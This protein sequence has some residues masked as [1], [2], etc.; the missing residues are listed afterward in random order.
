MSYET[1]IGTVIARAKRSN[2]CC[3]ALFLDC[4]AEPVQSDSEVLAMT[5]VSFVIHRNIK[6][7]KSHLL[8]VNR[9]TRFRDAEAY[10]RAGAFDAGSGAGGQIGGIIGPVGCANHM[11]ER[12][13]N[14]PKHTSA[15]GSTTL[16]FLCI[17]R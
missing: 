17:Y 3:T 5:L 4:F 1:Q 15:S 11:G 14:V 2:P 16:K 7:T 9:A 10:E 6:Q 13:R 12:A 8:V